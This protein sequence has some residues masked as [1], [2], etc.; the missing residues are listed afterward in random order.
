MSQTNPSTKEISILAKEFIIHGDQVRAWRL[1]FPDSKAVAETQHSKASI[2]FTCKKVRARIA[3]LHASSNA[4]SEKDFNMTVAEL[5]KKLSE[6]MGKGVDQG[7]L[8]AVVS[9]IAEFNKMD[10]NHAV[11]KTEISGGLEVTRKIIRVRTKKA[12]K[13]D[14]E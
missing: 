6:V 9:A 13:K 10:G 11:V 8:A 12:K 1:A 4:Q 14:S 3:E 2:A 5:K 7:K